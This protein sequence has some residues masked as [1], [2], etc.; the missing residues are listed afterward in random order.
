M[1]IFVS[2]KESFGNEVI[3]TQNSW[4]EKLVAPENERMRIKSLEDH[5]LDIRQS[6]RQKVIAELE[7]WYKIMEPIGND[8]NSLTYYISI[9]R[10]LKYKLNKLKGEK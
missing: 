9:F 4:K 7:K 2:E 10:D 1:E 3:H 8:C 5:D 6:E